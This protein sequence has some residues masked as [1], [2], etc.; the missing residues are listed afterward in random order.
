MIFP[1]WMLVAIPATWLI[2]IPANIAID[3]LV[4]YLTM[5]KHGV[6]EKKKTYRKTIFHVVCFG[7]FGDIVGGCLMLLSQ[8]IPFNWLIQ[9]DTALSWVYKNFINAIAYNPFESLIALIW[10]LGCMA[11]ASLIIYRCNLLY[12]FKGFQKDFDVDPAFVRK[13][14]FNLAVF[15]T[16]VLFLLPTG[17]F[18]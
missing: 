2:V 10:V 5:K 11:V 7:F 18:Y 15:T 13:L 12:T 16:P 6:T 4:I 14:S 17:W 1:I 3:S 8:Y 9:D